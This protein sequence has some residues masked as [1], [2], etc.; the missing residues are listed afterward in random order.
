MFG[1]FLGDEMTD[2]DKKDEPPPTSVRNDRYADEKVLWRGML[3]FF[4]HV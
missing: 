3:W 4:M 1:R 2:R